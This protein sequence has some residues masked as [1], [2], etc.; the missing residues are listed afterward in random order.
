MS[1]SSLFLLFSSTDAGPVFVGGMH[2]R[3]ERD[4]I[5]S[6]SKSGLNFGIPSNYIYDAALKSGLTNNDL[7]NTFIFTEN[8]NNMPFTIEASAYTCR[9][10]GL[11]KEN[12]E[13]LCRV[14]SGRMNKEHGY[15]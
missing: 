4:S 10:H 12:I 2:G 7:V 11:H 9:I 8:L 3:G 5:R 1:G 13:L 6:D 15:N 14:S